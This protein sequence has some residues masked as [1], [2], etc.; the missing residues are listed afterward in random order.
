[1]TN[2]L[3]KIIVTIV[4]KNELPVEFIKELNTI[5][6]IELRI[7]EK[8][9][10][11]AEELLKRIAES[12]MIV[13]DLHTK[14]SESVLS[15]AKALKTIVSTSFSLS[16]LDLEYCKQA[17]IQIISFPDFQSQNEVA[18][19]SREELNQYFHKH[20]LEAIKEQASRN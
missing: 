13:V 6:G 19:I 20:L 10:A 4:E 11:D 17:G 3:K 5:P 9:A 8:H 15:Q 16:H 1:M 7:F 12:E 2:N 14:Y 18:E